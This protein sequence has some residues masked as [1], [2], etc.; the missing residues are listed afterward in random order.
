MMENFIYDEIKSDLDQKLYSEIITRFPPEPNGYL[1]LG[2]AKSIVVNFELA[3]AF[4]GKT[5]LRFDDTNPSKEKEEYVDAISRDIHW[6]G[7][8][9]DLVTYASGYFEQ[10]YTCAALL[11]QKGLAYVCDLSPDEI[12]STRGDFIT[13]GTDSPY[14]DRTIETNLALFQDMRNGNFPE[15]HCVL[16]AKI[17]MQSPNMNLRDP[18]LYRISDHPHHR[19]GD[20][21][22]IYPMYDF[23]HPLEDLFENVSHS[24]C[25][26]EFADHRALYDWVILH[27]STYHKPRQIEFAKLQLENTVMGKRY[28]K[29][30]VNESVVSG[31]DD[32]RMPTLS[33]L[34]RRGYTP[35]SIRDFCLASGISKTNGVN[36]R[37]MLDH[38]LREDLKSTSP[39]LHA[40]TKPLKVIISNYPE[41]EIEGIL[42]PTNPDSVTSEVRPIFF[43]REIYIESDDFMLEP[44]KGYKRLSPG[45]E[46]RLMHAYFITCTDVILNEDGEIDHLLCTYDPQTKS[47]SGFNERKPKGTIHFVEASTAIKQSFHSFS[48]LTSIEKRD[49][50]VESAL[51]TIHT[52]HVQFVRNGYYAKDGNHFNLTASLK[53]SYRP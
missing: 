15:G 33:G 42:V 10:M 45:V 13:P 50:Y 39:R 41:G 36:E 11:I 53:S 23:A 22:N 40:V 16:R 37:D 5:H 19:T 44:I 6:L 17:D 8:T 52:T 2:H 21:W 24:I 9:P 38:F 43:S 34:R 51:S 26:L 35:K 27:C 48:D 29:K 3:K 25:T 28:L 18:I 46:V 4:H 31:W 20:A 47:G 49:G 1:H 14:R 32:P 12:A 7:Y 30:Q